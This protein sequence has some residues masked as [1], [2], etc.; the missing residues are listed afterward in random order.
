LPSFSSTSLSSSSPLSGAE[1]WGDDG[2]VQPEELSD[3]DSGAQRERLGAPDRPELIL[4]RYTPWDWARVFVFCVSVCSLCGCAAPDRP[5][6]TC[7]CD[8]PCEGLR[9]CN[10]LLWQGSCSVIVCVL[11]VWLCSAGLT[12]ECDSQSDGVSHAPCKVVS[13]LMVCTVCDVGRK[14]CRCCCVE[15]RSVLPVNCTHQNHSLSLILV[16]A[17]L[18]IQTAAIAGSSM[19]AYRACRFTGRQSSSS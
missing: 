15:G 9:V 11:S 19:R 12:R 3:T 4:K 6:L 5:E 16:L 13:E 1:D 18:P 8:T 7:E 14:R 2:Q 10:R 17:S